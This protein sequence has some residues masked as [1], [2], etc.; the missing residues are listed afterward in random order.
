[1]ENMKK[2]ILR[3]VLII[4]LLI[5]AFLTLTLISYLL[6]LL[7]SYSR[8][9]NVT[10]LEIENNQNGA[11]R[12]GSE[13]TILTYNIGF[14]AYTPEYSFF[15][16]TG[17][18]EN[19]KETKGKYGKAIDKESVLTTT[20][21]VIETL[22]QFDA[23]FVF[24]QEVDKKASRTYKVNQVN[25]I[26]SDFSN[27]GSVFAVNFHSAFLFYPLLDPHGKT[28]AGLLTLSK[29]RIENATR[30]SYPIATDFSKFFDLDRCFSVIR[31][32]TE[33]QKELVLIN[34]HMSAYDKGGKIRAKQLEVIQDFLSKERNKGNYIILGGDFNH[35]LGEE[36]VDVFPSKQKTPSWISVLKDSDIP[37]GFS[38]L[39]AE[40]A[41]SVP[42]CRGADIPY[43]KGVNYTAVIDG[44]IISDNIEASAENIDNDFRYSDHMPVR[45]SFVLK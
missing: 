24:L 25:M 35:I 13:Y 37:E 43:E 21:G 32:P 17:E 28:L 40:N 9:E 31:I 38:M 5:L 8:I 29:Y 22:K 30:I 12:T 41:T 26:R 7:F 4:A 45:L 34:S 3:F 20:Q 23:D 1:M 36:L 2:G 6:Y 33:N 14:G 18:M 27:Y 15:M 10:S 42:T 39:R 11:V 16:D 19:G 44:F